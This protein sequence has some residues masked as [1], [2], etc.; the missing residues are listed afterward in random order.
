[1][2]RYC[3]VLYILFL[4]S[5]NGYTQT[6]EVDSTRPEIALVSDTQ[7]P[8]GVERI[9]LR[10]NKNA[11][12]TGKILQDIIDR[13]PRALFM[14]GDVVSVGYKEKKWKQID[15]FLQRSRQLGISVAAILGNHDVLVHS[16]RGETAFNRRFPD[17]VN[18]G[19]Y[20][21]IDSIGFVLLNSNFGMLTAAQL[22]KQQ[23]FYA[24]TM[25]QLD[26]D[27]SVKVIVVACHHSPYTNSKTVGSNA[28]VQEQFVPIFLQSAKAKLFV[29]GHAH[30]FEHFTIKGKD[31]LT[32]GGGGGLHQ[33]LNKRESR[34]QSLSEGY[35]PE[36]HYVLL[37]RRNNQIDI[38][39]RRLKADF[40]GFTND[41]EFTTH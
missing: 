20:K 13:M 29:S 35:Y 36:F 19:F 23:D 28:R 31:F 6:T 30:A 39:S 18:T 7:E 12:A 37:K 4:M 15:T 41:Y 5:T 40:S 14:L 1:M 10:Y 3:I 9:F 26:K 32:I 22:K 17:Q 11:L 33:P 34:R 27:S 21:L 16:A 2:L 25:A 38:I 8:L 24:A